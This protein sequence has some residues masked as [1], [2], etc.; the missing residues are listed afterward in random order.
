[1]ATVCVIN[2]VHPF[3]ASS[4]LCV[5]VCACVA[6]KLDL[7]ALRQ[8]RGA[9]VHFSLPFLRALEYTDVG[10]KKGT[11]FEHSVPWGSGQKVHFSLLATVLWSNVVVL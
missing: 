8:R 2:S 6:Q 7:E 5:C 4:L 9:S 10:A 3:A 11:I 1:M